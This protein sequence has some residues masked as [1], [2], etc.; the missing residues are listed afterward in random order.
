MHIRTHTYT[1]THA[2]TRPP[3][4]PP[5]H[6]ASSRSAH[7]LGER[8]L[9]TKWAWAD[10]SALPHSGPPE[11]V[12]GA[13]QIELDKL[14]AVWAHHAQHQPLCGGAQQV[15]RNERP[16]GLVCMHTRGWG[17]MS[18]GQVCAC[19]SAPLP[20]HSLPPHSI[21]PPPPSPA[22]F[23]P[24]LHSLDSSLLCRAHVYTW[25]RKWA[26]QRV[27]CVRCG[28]KAGR[29]TS[30]TP[31]ARWQVGHRHVGLLHLEALGPAPGKR[32]LEHD[33]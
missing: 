27:K 32:V 8:R 22:A 26:R 9:G 20:S 30:C 13:L 33:S 25:C 2:R 29:S 6:T 3:T 7:D 14:D 17:S 1:C 11:Q 5:T 15:A 16:P 4:H 28:R 23:A 10:L 19:W 31:S 21:P 18:G 24:G 12:D